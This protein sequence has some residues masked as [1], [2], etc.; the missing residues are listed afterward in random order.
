VADA[1][2]DSADAAWSRRLA[3]R[4]SFSVGLGW[5]PG[6]ALEGF[7]REVFKGARPGWRILEIG[8]GSADV[9]LWAAETGRGLV[10]IASDLHRN[11]QAV[12]RHPDVLFVGGAR[13]EAL[14]FADGAF[15]L[16]VSNFAVEYAAP[17]SALPELNRV[18]RAGGSAALVLH[19]ADSIVTANSRV[20]LQTHAA[21][22]A[23]GVPERVRRA[24]G[25][26][27]DHLTRRK[28]LKEALKVRG[29]IATQT[30]SFGGIDHF[31]VA[32]RLLEGAAGARQD[33]A[34]LDEAVATRVAISREQLRVALDPAGL[35]AF[36]RRLS[37]L[38]F[39]IDVSALTCTY[40]TGEADKVG[41]IALLAKRP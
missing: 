36:C 8:C 38:D 20:T 33:L 24:A 22:D 21:L 35:Q 5:G 10:A 37:A 15:D 13:A 23:A 3:N 2:P 9:S 40:E 7:W 27:P 1:D 30:L 14:P 6:Q 17:D 32:E 25:L 18:L 34:R 16:V 28:L 19:S 41:W 39:A 11:P 26:R 12:R 31:V 29:G 4:P